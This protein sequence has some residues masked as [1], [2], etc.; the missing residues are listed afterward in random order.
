MDHSD[1]LGAL[2]TAGL[3]GKVAL[4]TGAGRRRGIGHGVCLQLARSG[5]FVMVT[6]VVRNDSDRRSLDE[7]VAACCEV[8]TAEA[9]S[10]DVT[11]PTDVAAAIA[12]TISRFGRID[13][14]V[15]NA[16]T[17][18]GAGSVTE[19][20]LPRWHQSWNVNVMGMVHCIQAAA[21]A[22]ISSKGAIVNTASLAGIGAVP[23]MA[24]YI[25]TKFAVVGLTRAAAADLGPLGVRVNAVCPGMIETDMGDLEVFHEAE[26]QALTPDVVRQQLIGDVPLGRWGQPGDVAHAVSWLLSP[27][28]SYLTGVCLPVAG[29]LAAGL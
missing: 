8:G 2:V 12:A 6:D 22:L 14:L 11:D 27:A 25:T 17:P 16:G 26:R 24:A 1:G 19:C 23:G 7:A 5:A 10:L 9:L 4:V 20:E 29:G 15:N 21:P 13:G 3:D 18:A 28:S